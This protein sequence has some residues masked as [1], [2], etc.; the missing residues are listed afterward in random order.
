MRVIGFGLLN[1]ESCYGRLPDPVYT[2]D[3]GQPLSSW[4]FRLA[5]FIESIMR[6]WDFQSRWDAPVNQ[7]LTGSPHYCYCLPSS[8]SGEQVQTNVV[9]ITGPETAFNG[10]REYSLHEIDPDH[11]R[12]ARG[13]RAAR[14]VRM[15]RL[16][17]A[18]GEE[19]DT[20]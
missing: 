6:D 20:E 9:L 15:R 13:G 4:R 3:Q 2:G 5:G 11:H 14:G 19:E 10:E 16:L 8:Y 1:H 12:T 18:T 7:W 17:A